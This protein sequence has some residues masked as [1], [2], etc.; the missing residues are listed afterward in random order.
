MGTAAQAAKPAPAPVQ[1]KSA[2]PMILAGVAV[3]ALGGGGAYVFLGSSSSPTPAAVETAAKTP[4][5]AVE[6]PKTAAAEP[7]K[8]PEPKPEPEA[9]PE[10]KPEPKPDPALQ[11]AGLQDQLAALSGDLSGSC[12][13]LR[14]A[15]ET[16]G[17]APLVLALAPSA[18]SASEALARLTL[19][20]ETAAPQAKSLTLPDTPA[21]CGAVEL[22]NLAH[23]PGPLGLQVTGL[24]QGKVKAG[25][26][27]TGTLTGADANTRLYLIGGATGRVTPLALEGGRFALTLDLA[28]PGQA[29]ELLLAI[30]PDGALPSLAEIQDGQ[31]ADSVIR[32]I[33]HGL[34]TEGRKASFDLLP[35][36][37]EK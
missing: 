1:K 28:A 12:R 13:F 11:R 16:A 19:P 7:E 31:A 24:T 23:V 25:Q 15:P 10:A 36:T 9:K 29:Q 35:F 20:G 6:A 14:L 8:A 34:K 2:L 3:L 22:A 4:E 26:S 21:F 30:A 33:G 32:H 37:L 5:P 17:A 27:L 18:Q